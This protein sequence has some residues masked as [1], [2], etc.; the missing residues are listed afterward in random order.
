MT[1]GWVVP[2]MIERPVGGTQK[3]ENT[4]QPSSSEEQ[5]NADVLGC[6]RADW[7]LIGGGSRGD[8]NPCQIRMRNQLDEP[9]DGVGF[10]IKCR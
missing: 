3:L 8:R 7:A 6:L 10:F 4:R 5:L 1:R 2:M 9:Y